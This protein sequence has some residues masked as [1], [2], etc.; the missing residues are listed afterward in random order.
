MPVAELIEQALRGVRSEHTDQEKS[1]NRSENPKLNEA[2]PKFLRDCW[3][4]FL[5]FRH[6]SPKICA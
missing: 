5:I 3:T 6:R 4:F 2:L 1:G